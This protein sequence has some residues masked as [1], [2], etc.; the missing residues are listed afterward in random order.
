MIEEKSKVYKLR[1]DNNKKK[2]V[3]SEKKF[4]FKN[5]HFLKKQNI[6]QKNSQIKTCY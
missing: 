5:Y 3:Y 1:D 2:P 4:V 6:K